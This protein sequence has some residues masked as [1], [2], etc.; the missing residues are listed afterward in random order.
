LRQ[1]IEQYLAEAVV[2]L[3]LGGGGN[4][5]FWAVHPGGPAILDSIEAALA[6]E[7]GKLTASRHVLREYGNM[8]GVSVIF[9]LDK[10]RVGEN[11]LRKLCP[12]PARLTVSART[13][14]RLHEGVQAVLV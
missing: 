7:P 11:D 2:P 13:Q 12:R 1:V 8:L 14:L 10:L 9:V 3:G 4:D 5:L 6:L